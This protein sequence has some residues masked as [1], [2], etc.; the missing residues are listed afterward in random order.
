MYLN[1]W[2]EYNA[3]NICNQIYLPVGSIVAT[4]STEDMSNYKGTWTKIASGYALKSA[5]LNDT[6]LDTGGADTVTTIPSASCASHSLTAS[7]IPAHALTVNSWSAAASGGSHGHTYKAAYATTKTGNAG[8][9]TGNKNVSGG[10]NTTSG[11]AGAHAHGQGSAYTAYQGSGTGHS[12]TIT[13]SSA[14]F[15]VHQKMI[16]VYVWRRTA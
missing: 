4:L 9:Y 6:A 8:S 5:D 13:F 1:S 14:T 15:D 16:Y 3:Y 10:T 12:H 11:S 7:E 2:V